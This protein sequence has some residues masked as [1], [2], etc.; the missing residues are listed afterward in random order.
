MADNIALVQHQLDRF[1]VVTVMDAMLYDY[2]TGKPILKLDTL[3]V[4]NLTFDG[5][6]KEI[7]G[8][9]AADLLLTYNHSRTVNVEITDALLSLYSLQQLWGSSIQEVSVIRAQETKK[10]AAA[11]T[12]PTWTNAFV[13]KDGAA[14]P[15]VGTDLFVLNKTKGAYVSATPAES[16]IAI[17][18]EIVAYGYVSVASVSGYNPVE[19]VLKSTTFPERVTLVGRTVFLDEASGKEVLAEIEIPKFQFGN[20]FDFNMDAE[21]DAATF[22][23]SGVALADGTSKEIIKIKTLAEGTGLMDKAWENPY[24]A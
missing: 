8:G 21:G 13:K 7:R 14:S 16:S 2:S 15:V 4:S 19:T 20:S 11:D 24:L 22:N 5:S 17:G 9:M 1:G 23:F 6:S 18:D 12:I 10:A 3:K